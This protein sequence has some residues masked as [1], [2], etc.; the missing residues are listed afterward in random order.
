MSGRLLLIAWGLALALGGVAATIVVASDH[1]DNKAATLALALTIGLSF[2]GS[3]L[4]ALWRRPQNNTGFRS[5]SSGTS[6][7]SAR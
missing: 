2:V 4:I 1:T 5:P 3:G 7:S 6:G